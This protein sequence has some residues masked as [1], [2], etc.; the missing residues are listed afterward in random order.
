MLGAVAAGRGDGSRRVVGRL[1]VVL[2]VLALLTGPFGS[3]DHTNY[4]AYGRISALGGDPYLTAAEPVVA[5]PTRSSPRSSR[6]GP[7]R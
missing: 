5:A 4:A 2:G 7:T 6:R 1:P 3:A